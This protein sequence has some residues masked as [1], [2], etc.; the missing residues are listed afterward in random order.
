MSIK[1]DAI[2]YIILIYRIR[3]LKVPCLRIRVFAADANLETIKRGTADHVE[4]TAGLVS[5][6]LSNNHPQPSEIAF[7][8]ANTHAAPAGLGKEAAP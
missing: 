4:L 1:T 7:L 2:F 8:I 6:Y 5:A 3:Q